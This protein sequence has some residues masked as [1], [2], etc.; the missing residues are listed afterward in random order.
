M[1]K[2]IAR[3]RRACRSGQ[4]GWALMD[5]IASALVV[6]LAFMGTFLA[7]DASTKTATSDIRKSTAYD[8]AQNELD[9]MRSLGDM[10][11]PSLLAQENSILPP[12]SPS[13][14]VTLGGVTYSI[15]DRAYYVQDIGTDVTDV[16]GND[17]AT[18][19]NTTAQFV[20]VKATVTW[21]GVSGATG[22][23]GTYTAPP[24]VLD[25]Y[26]AP[27]GGD[28]QTNTAT[29][30]VFV[31]DRLGN[32]I[33]S[34]YVRLYKGPGYATPI[35]TERTSIT[36]CVLFTGVARGDYQIRISSGSN[37]FDVYMTSNDVNV[38][39]KIPSRA[40]LSRTIKI[41]QPVTVTPA[42]ITTKAD[43]SGDETV[44][45]GTSAANSLAGPWIATAPEIVEISG[46]EFMPNISFM[47][48]A[49]AA[50]KNLMFPLKNGYA[51]YTGPC[52]INDPG[53]ANYVTMPTVGNNAYWGAGTTY[54]NGQPQLRLPSF[55]VQLTSALTPKAGTGV[56]AVRLLGKAG[57]TS[58][59]GNC[60]QNSTLF[61]TWIQL[62]GTVD[63]SGMLVNT[64][65][66][67]PPGRYDICMRQQAY[68]DTWDHTWTMR[69][70]LDQNVDNVFGAWSLHSYP[71]A[72]GSTSS[73]A[74]C[75]PTSFWT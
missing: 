64:A 63:T 42:F 55:R 2:L 58:T 56:I 23:T 27:E 21:P 1:R 18:A 33:A 26:F 5:A 72:S 34:Q 57:T 74:G 69:Y 71:M 47:P 20:Y 30:R 3:Y 38:P 54:P 44:P 48:H 68:K 12:N 10:N 31:N 39:I 15:W 24:A 40:T 41:S 11:L 51:A 60:G 49:D 32:A 13:R 28:L 53:S 22:A 67:L 52:D 8:L 62:P 36:G 73:P 17:A 7:I 35:K 4:E 70:L 29:L 46:T 37:K 19:G 50:I 43:N 16:C 61:S 6:V 65:Y 25:S 9:R 75:P 45:V 14:T 66:A 59:A